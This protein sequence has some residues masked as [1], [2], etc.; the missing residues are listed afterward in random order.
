MADRVYV[1]TTFVSY[2]TARP[3]RDLVIAAHQLGQQRAQPRLD[4]ADDLLR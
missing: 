4:A 1:E 3:S 2:L